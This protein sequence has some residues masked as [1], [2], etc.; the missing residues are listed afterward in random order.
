MGHYGRRVLKRH[1]K[2]LT[3]SSDIGRPLE[4]IVSLGRELTIAVQ[5][6]LAT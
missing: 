6:T 3:A 4:G 1:D 5:E 2:V